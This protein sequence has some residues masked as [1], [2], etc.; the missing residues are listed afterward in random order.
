MS[1]TDL[2]ALFA[3]SVYQQKFQKIIL[4]PKDV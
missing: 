4:M 3:W 2:N 1:N